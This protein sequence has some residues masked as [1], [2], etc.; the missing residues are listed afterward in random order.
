MTDTKR[1]AAFWIIVVFLVL[2]MVMLVMGQTTAVFDYD[3]AVQLQLQ[4][5]A[6][7]I[8]EYGVQVNR[9]FGVGDTLVYLVLMFASVVGLILRKRWSLFTTAAVMGISAYWAVVCIFM[10]GFLEGVPGYYLV[11]GV[12]YWFIMGI[13]MVFGVWGLLYLMLRGDRLIE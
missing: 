7:D 9:A 13:Y 10:L 3:F 2:S 12:E 1:P 4:E 6:E 11:P 5:G 8:S